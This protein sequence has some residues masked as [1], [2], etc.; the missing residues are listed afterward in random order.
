MVRAHYIPEISLLEG[1]LLRKAK[2]LLAFFVEVSTCWFHD[3]FSDSVTT[4]YF[5]VLA[6]MDLKVLGLNEIYVGSCCIPTKFRV[7]TVG[8]EIIRFCYNI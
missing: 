7:G 4:R 2:L 8:R 3:S 1:F 5:P 6:I